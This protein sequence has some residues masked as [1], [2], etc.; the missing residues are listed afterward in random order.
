[1]CTP[2]QSGSG[3]QLFTIDVNQAREAAF[4]LDDIFHCN[5]SNNAYALVDCLREI[6]AQ[7]LLD[8]SADVRDYLLLL[9]MF[10]PVCNKQSFHA[11]LTFIK[12]LYQ[13]PRLHTFNFGYEYFSFMSSS[14]REIVTIL[15]K[16]FVHTPTRLRH[17]CAVLDVKFVSS[18]RVASA[19]FHK[20]L[21]SI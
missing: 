2:F 7:D 3:Q 8:A 19:L 15:R 17:Y 14:N 11:R 9:Y 16:Y 4:G 18:P 6:P 13:V 5:A 1:M 20:E 21:R 10:I 12:P